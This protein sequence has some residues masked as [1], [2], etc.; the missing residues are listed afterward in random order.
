MTSYLR[1]ALFALI[2]VSLL[3][4]PGCGPEAELM[5]RDRLA[6]VTSVAILPFEDAPGRYSRQSGSATCGFITSELAKSKRFRI[7]ERSK[8]KAIMNEQQLQAAEMIDE[9]TAVKVGRMLGVHAVVLGSV[10]EYEMDKTTVYIHIVP[11]VSKEYKIGATIRLIDVSNGE[12][13]Y[14]HSASGASGN[15]FTEAGKL[16]ARKL[17]APLVKT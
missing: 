7:V 13:I 16:A 11:I 9:D 2:V 14:A 5:D 6:N 1:K 15:S 4:V 3:S 10:C 8:L 17:V 12:I